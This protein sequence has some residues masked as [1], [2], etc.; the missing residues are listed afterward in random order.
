M[1]FAKTTA[2]G[3]YEYDMLV[4][5][6][7]SCPIT[8]SKL[9]NK[10]NIYVERENGWSKPDTFPPRNTG[11]GRWGLD[12]NVSRI[13][14]ALELPKDSSLDEIAEAAHKGWSECYTFWATHRPWERNIGSYNIYFPPGRDLCV[15]NKYER[16]Q[17]KFADL[18]D[19]NKKTYRQ[20]ATFIKNECM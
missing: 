2:D 9:A 1:E 11:P 12:I 15:R 18:D 19:F 17:T 14:R 5:P 6:T 4:Y 13:G 20:M 8:I 16:S 10:M 3:K 7:N